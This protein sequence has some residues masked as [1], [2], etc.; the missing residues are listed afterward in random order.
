VKT[1]ELINE[2]RVVLQRYLSEKSAGERFGDFCARVLWNETPLKPPPCTDDS[3]T[4][5]SLEP[6]TAPKIAA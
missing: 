5:C 6:G 1:D 2:L 3:R 4:A